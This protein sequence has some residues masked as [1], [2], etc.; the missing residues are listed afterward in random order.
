MAHVSALLDL[1]LEKVSAKVVD[2][3]GNG[4]YCH[5]KIEGENGGCYITLSV[6]DFAYAERLVAAIN[7]AAADPAASTPALETEEAA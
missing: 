4:R 1:G 5:V 7:A 3:L 6:S 2:L